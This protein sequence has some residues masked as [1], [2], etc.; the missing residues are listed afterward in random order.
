MNYKIDENESVKWVNKENK[1]NRFVTVS[2]F[3]DWIEFQFD[4]K[5]DAAKQC[6]ARLIN[7]N[8][9]YQ[10][11]KFLHVVRHKRKVTC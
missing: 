2:R 4:V 11:G 3:F 10:E 6:K 8:R 9:L 1:A 5:R 7:E